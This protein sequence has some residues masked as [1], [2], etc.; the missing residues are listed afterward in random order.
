MAQQLE[1]VTCNLCGADSTKPVY[2][3]QGRSKF[4]Y[5]A[6]LTYVRCTKCGLVYTDP[7]PPKEKIE[8]QYESEHYRD[9]LPKDTS[10]YLRKILTNSVNRLAFVERFKKEGKLLDV[11]CAQGNFIS[12]AR[13]KGWDVTGV[14]VSTRFSGIARDRFGL[15]AITGVLEDQ[16]FEPES[17][18]VITCFD[19]IEHLRDPLAYL[20]LC[21][22]LLKKGGIFIA[23]TC[24]L[25]SLHQMVLGKRWQSDPA[26]HL[27]LF[28]PRTIR[29]IAEKAGFKVIMVNRRT[30]WERIIAKT[31]VNERPLRYLAGLAFRIASR[32]MRKESMI[33]LVAQ[34]P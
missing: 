13:L 8:E 24:N 2:T 14:E 21:R 6:P 29:A 5:P 34:T 7:R 23:E 18:D 20:H 30:G 31:D 17:F 32:L 16:K 28:N 25:S 33:V 9:M 22:R 15:N 4:S 10:R 12:V 1:H 19:V 11:G 26:Q 27:Y 3:V